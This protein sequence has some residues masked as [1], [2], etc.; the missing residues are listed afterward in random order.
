MNYRTT[1]I[2]IILLIGVAATYFLFFNKPIENDSRDKKPTISETYDLPRDDIEKLQLSYA[3]EAYKTITIVKD[4]GGMWQIT[5]PF[6]AHADLE[7]VNTV[8]DDFVKKRVRQTFD[9]T[10]YDQY[11]LDHP[12]IT[13]QLWKGVGSSPKLFLV[14]NKGI[15]YSVY[16]KEKSEQHIFII[17]SSALDD[18]AISTTDIRDRSVIKFNPNSITEIAYHKPEQFTCVKNG[19]TWQMTHPIS[20]NADS[21]D[22]SYM[23]SALETMQV[24]T[25]EL[26]GKNVQESLSKYGL[27]TPRIKLT[28]TDRN[29]SYGLAIGSTVPSS[30]D[31]QNRDKNAVYVQ[32][33][34]Q[35][36]IYTVTDHIFKLLNKTTFDLRD[37]RLVDFQR[38]DVTKFEIQH[39]Q[40]KI[41][42][43]KIEGTRLKK[44][45]WEIQ[46]N[47]NEMADPQAIIADPKAVSDLIYGVDSLEA[48]SYITNPTKNL[49]LYGLNTPSYN[50]QFTVRGNEKPI[51]LSVGDF[52]QND[53]VY[54]KTNMSDQIALV[55]R[56][57][58]DMIADGVSWLRE[59]QIFKFTIDDPIRC[60]VKYTE[61]SR[62][63]VAFT[64]QRLGTN[65]RL[66][67][68]VQEKAKDAEVNTLLYELIDLKAE[69]YI[70]LSFDGREN[71][72]TDVRTGFN[73]PL[74]QITVELRNK[75]VLTL[76]VGKTDSSGSYYA[77]IQN[78]PKHIFLLKSELVPKLK[79]KLEWLRVDSEEQ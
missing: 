79:P 69:E 17:E 42:G 77:R 7:K 1:F 3:D 38:G 75:T 63:P 12:K 19:D 64:C 29:K 73:S 49:S 68:P 56:D 23:L 72:L 36:G 2:I 71:K 47:N 28:L 20:A 46:G 16:V 26:D 21:D 61:T 40:E 35:G 44:D 65:W 43:E 50:V 45:L 66:T 18:L 74:L 59:K 54:V 27:D 24:S 6:N 37:K 52:A 41:E 51:V 25:F 4:A 32:A 5:T 62:D 39:G 33:L 9:V 76:Q 22:I 60:I 67:H 11:G 14:G 15:N 10:E 31:Q 57:L 34:H 8:L 55:K 30:M 53:T 13:V 48:A 70:G 78:Q 58:I